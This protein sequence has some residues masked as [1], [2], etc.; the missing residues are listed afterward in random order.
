[1]KEDR[2]K[3]IWDHPIF[4]K[5]EREL[6]EWEKER[7]FCRHGVEHL[8]D[9]ARIATLLVYEAHMEKE[10]PKDVIYG[11]ALLHDIGRLRQYKDGT[12]HE[13][14]SAR[15]AKDILKD[16][17][18]SKEE[19]WLMTEAIVS[20]RLIEAE[21]EKNLKGFLYKADKLS[22]NC[23]FCPAKKNCNWEKDKKNKY[24]LY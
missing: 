14:E 11:A 6:A 22:R 23:V 10:Y 1:V 4:Q 12:P 18:Y 2:I 16:C 13:V 20:H 24:L 7:T 8:L 19:I 15:L 17:D 9:V 21:K 3:N 5:I